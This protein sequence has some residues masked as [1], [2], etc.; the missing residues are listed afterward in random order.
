MGSGKEQHMRGKKIVFIFGLTHPFSNGVGNC[1]LSYGGA[2]ARR[3]HHCSVLTCRLSKD[4]PVVETYRN[5]TFHR[6]LRYTVAGSRFLGILHLGTI[7]LWQI[8]RHLRQVRPD[9]L[10]G[11]MLDYGVI[12]ALMGWL[13]G[14]PSITN[15]QGSDVDEVKTLFRKLETLYS[16][17]SNTIVTTTNNEFKQKML[18]RHRRDIALWPNI[19]DEEMVPKVEPVPLEPGKFHLMAVGRLVRMYGIE[20]K[21]ISYIIKAMAE[22]EGCHLHI[23]GEGPLRSEYEALI[24]ELGIADRVTLHGQQSRETVFRYMKAVDALVFPSLTEGL[25]MTVIEAMFVGLPVVTT[26][27]GGQADHIRDGVNGFFV[28][29][30]GSDSIRDK[31]RQ[32]QKNPALLEKVSQASREYFREHFSFEAYA[33]IFEQTVLAVRPDQPG[34]KTAPS[35]LKTQPRK[36][37]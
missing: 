30:A 20:T 29:K 26:R 27:V 37:S 1:T 17:K 6:I 2:L 33:R 28:E 10:V 14:I 35:I 32:L 19:L 11:M 4:D 23:L 21:G 8:Y 36:A 18:R 24:D 5:V 9:Y 31:V 25:S 13:L 16:L 15:A 7:G 3:G 22:L 12:S 34:E